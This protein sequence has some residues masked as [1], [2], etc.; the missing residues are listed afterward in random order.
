[1]SDVIAR[2]LLAMRATLEATLAS[3][4]AVLEAYII[5]KKDKGLVK[6]NHPNKQDIKTMT[7]PTAF[8]CPDCKLQ[9]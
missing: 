9:G 6:C 8:Y 7:N 3:I 1:M 5:E 2:Q 4:D